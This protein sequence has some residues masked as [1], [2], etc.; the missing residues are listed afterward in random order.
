MSLYAN[1]L[2]LAFMTAYQ[3]IAC[4][5]ILEIEAWSIV[6]IKTHDSVLYCQVQ[7]VQACDRQVCITQEPR[8]HRFH[9]TV[10]DNS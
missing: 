7:P 6:Y 9:T 8:K 3:P 2:G 4:N 1:W 5:Y 10:T